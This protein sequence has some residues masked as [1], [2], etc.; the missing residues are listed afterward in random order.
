MTSCILPRRMPP[1]TPYGL[2]FV[3]YILAMGNRA[4][5]TGSTVKYLLINRGCYTHAD[6]NYSFHTSI[7]TPLTT[8]EKMQPVHTRLYRPEYIDTHA[9]TPYHAISAIR[10]GI[11]GG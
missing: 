9:V 1:V 8:I 10:G 7:L 11:T 6:I 5:L 3:P 4:Y 2:F